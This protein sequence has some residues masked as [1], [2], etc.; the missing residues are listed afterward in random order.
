MKN[1]LLFPIVAIVISFTAFSC[2]DSSS[3]EKIFDITYY[4]NNTTL[5]G[6]KGEKSIPAISS[7]EYY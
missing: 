1:Y 4:Y 2:D 5:K 3:E 6:L 7:N